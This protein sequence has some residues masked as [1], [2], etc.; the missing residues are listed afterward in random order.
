M[1]IHREDS[2]LTLPPLIHR[3]LSTHLWPIVTATADAIATILPTSTFPRRIRRRILE[4]IREATKTSA[5]LLLTLGTSLLATAAAI[6]SGGVRK[7]PSRTEIGIVPQGAE[8]DFDRSSGSSSDSSSDD[9]DMNRGT[10]AAK[11]EGQADVPAP[12]AGKPMLP[13]CP[14]PVA[15]HPA[16]QE[17]AIISSSLLE[18]FP[19]PPPPPPPAHLGASAALPSLP[20]PPSPPSSSP[21]IASPPLLPSSPPSPR[22]APSSLPDFSPLN[23][24][25]LDD[26]FDPENITRSL[27]PFTTSV[28][29][30]KDRLPSSF[31]FLDETALPPFTAALAETLDS[32]LQPFPSPSADPA[33][34]HTSLAI[35]TLTRPPPFPTLLSPLFEHPEPPSP[36]TADDSTATQTEEEEDGTL[37]GQAS[38]ASSHDRTDPSTSL[39][40]PVVVPALAPPPPEVVA[41]VDAAL[42]TRL[43]AVHDALQGLPA[44]LVL[45]LLLPTEPVRSAVEVV[46]AAA[47]PQDILAPTEKHPTLPKEPAA[48]PRA[49]ITLPLTPPATPPAAPTTVAAKKPSTP[50][51]DAARFFPLSPPT[52]HGMVDD[53]IRRLL[54]LD[55]GGDA[56][57][58][59]DVAPDAVG[60][61]T[62]TVLTVGACLCTLDDGAGPLVDRRRGD[63]SGGGGGA[64]DEDNDEGVSGTVES[65][66]PPPVPPKDEEDDDGFA[67]DAAVPRAAATA[68]RDSGD[69]LEDEEEEDHPSSVSCWS[70]SSD[71]QVLSLGRGASSGGGG[72]G[73]VTGTG[74]AG[75]TAADEAVSSSAGSTAS[76]SPTPMVT[77][78]VAK[79]RDDDDGGDAT[80]EVEADPDSVQR[81]D[82]GFEDIPTQSLA[83]VLRL[84][85][86]WTF[87]FANEP[88]AADHPTAVAG[89]DVILPRAFGYLSATD[90]AA[91]EAVCRGWA[92]VL[93]SSLGTGLWRRLWGLATRQEG[94]TD[95]EEEEGAF[96]RAGLKRRV[97]N[98]AR[99]ERAAAGFAARFGAFA[100]APVVGV[101][102]THRLPPVPPQL[103]GTP[104]KRTM[105]DA[106]GAGVLLRRPASSSPQ[107]EARQDRAF[108]LT[109]HPA[110]LSSIDLHDPALAFEL[111]DASGGLAA[112][113]A[114]TMVLPEGLPAVRRHVEL[115]KRLCGV[116]TTASGGGSEWVPVAAWRPG[117]DGETFL[118]YSATAAKGARKL[119]VE[120]GGEGGEEKVGGPVGRPRL[121]HVGV[122]RW[123]LGAVAG[124]DGQQ[125]PRRRGLARSV[126][127]SKLLQEED[128]IRWVPFLKADAPSDVKLDWDDS[129]GEEDV[130]TAAASNEGGGEAA[131]RRP[132]IRRREH[133]RMDRLLRLDLPE[134]FG[135]AVG[136][137][138]GDVF[139]VAFQPGG[140]PA[141]DPAAAGTPV[142]APGRGGPMK[143]PVE[144]APDEGPRLTS[145]PLG[146]EFPGSPWA[147]ATPPRSPLMSRKRSSSRIRKR[148]SSQSLSDLKALQAS[149]GAAAAGAVGGEQ[150]RPGAPPALPLLQAY[151]LVKVTDPGPTAIPSPTLLWTVP[152]PVSSEH[153]I[154]YMAMNAT[155]VAHADHPVPFT[156]S[157]RF[158]ERLQHLVD[159]HEA[160]MVRLRAVR[161]G[162]EMGK[163]DLSKRRIWVRALHLTS[164]FLCVVGVQATAMPGGGG[165]VVDRHPVLRN[166]MGR[167]GG[168]GTGMGGFGGGGGGGGGRRGGAQRQPQMPA[169]PPLSPLVVCLFRLSDLACLCELVVADVLVPTEGCG[170]GVSACAAAVPTGA[171][172]ET[173]GDALATVLTVWTHPP[174][175]LQASLMSEGASEADVW[176]TL[177]SLVRLDMTS[178]PRADVKIYRRRAE[179]FLLPNAGIG[180]GM[181]GD[182]GGMW[183]VLKDSV[184]RP[185]GVFEEENLVAWGLGFCD[186]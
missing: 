137:L 56:G 180:G 155:V 4:C 5:S 72:A 186:A 30:Q 74:V 167:G 103:P 145:S 123:P 7:D 34:P 33:L 129:D 172:D 63:V 133:E 70:A 3:F 177:P 83:P 90:L 59:A 134:E 166:L 20:S 41:S 109:A 42:V 99:W 15:P 128:D 112:Q 29:N 35:T 146:E 163:I 89:R 183:V 47:E 182:P 161:D 181:K 164:A 119:L 98:L 110:S 154:P 18:T 144:A 48:P 57:A 43:A 2:T 60:T 9:Q 121:L 80:W 85:V 142:I 40:V 148:L 108:F 93:R 117:G 64:V 61:P 96:S 102:S 46:A 156:P 94:R 44:E 37:V 169:T 16:Q 68:G 14:Q 36:T 24:S 25:H 160:S 138:H 165:G 184:E 77:A 66:P 114:W 136:C 151:S 116:P 170:F 26:L 147:I 126:S 132:R 106:V 176:P 173:A 1:Q 125:P 124:G 32:Q 174:S 53:A 185:E 107:A 6:D 28:D 171:A 100:P 86:D 149:I 115:S 152:R 76:A 69:G 65:P 122:G 75:E 54:L 111:R 113:P 81:D 84:P 159:G 10:G 140:G 135:E 45:Q 127:A 12:V 118:F 178:G 141:I 130:V 39:D 22:S 143:G 73:G 8:V 38:P 58:A 49:L 17:I 19:S 92:G 52:P 139:V 51:K 71:T 27:E 162:A 105:V 101:E 175:S 82:V 79:G 158:R 11:A 91:C 62:E 78:E 95:N 104:W 97:L 21:A 50:S 153:R 179:R 13:P 168:P 55:N 88:V 67:L 120:A 23:T 31:F 150:G 87:V 157:Q 131:R